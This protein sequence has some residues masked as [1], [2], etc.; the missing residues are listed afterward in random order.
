MPDD[1]VLQLTVKAN[2]GE[3]SDG[4]SQMAAVTQK[5][6]SEMGG[7]FEK[8]ESNVDR[9]QHSVYEARE[10]VTLLGE[11]VGVRLPRAVASLLARIGPLGAVLEVAFP[12]L[13]ALALVDVVS[14]LIEKHE[15][16]AQELR[17]SAEEETNLTI[18]DRDRTESL[19]LT[20]QKLE[21]QIGKIENRPSANKL[22]EALLEA[23]TRA[24]ELASSLESDFTKFGAQI[25]KDTG[26]VTNLEVALRNVPW[27]QVAIASSTLGVGIA[28]SAAVGVT[29]YKQQAESLRGVQSAM[30][31]VDEARLQMSETK[32][33]ADQAAAIQTLHNAYLNLKNAA[34][35]ALAEVKVDSPKNVELIGALT[36]S[37]IHATASMADMNEMAKNL[38][39]SLKSAGQT[40]ATDAAERAAKSQKEVLNQRLADIDLEKSRVHEL[41]ESGKTDLSTWLATQQQATQAATGAQELYHAA[42][43]KIYQD[44]GLA[45]KADAASKELGAE[46]TKDLAKETEELA[47]AEEKH[48][49]E[50]Q[51]IEA[52]WSSIIGKNVTEEW[53][54]QEKAVDE[55]AQA[56]YTLLRSQESLNQAKGGEGKY[57]PQIDAIKE[58]V[59]ARVL[60]KRQEAEQLMAIY[61]QEEAD[62]QASIQ[63]EIASKQ[64]LL[65][66]AKEDQAHA[67]SLYGANSPEAIA[68]QAQYDKELA[69]FNDLQAKKLNSQKQSDEKISAEQQQLTIAL[70]NIQ[71]KYFDEVNH[72]L[73]TLVADWIK[74]HQS[75]KQVVQNMLVDGLVSL[76]QYV[77]GWVEKKAEMW[78][79]DKILGETA[80]T[81]DTASTTA[82]NVLQVI[83]YAAVASAAAAAGAAVGGPLAAAAAAAETDAVVLAYLPQASAREGYDVPNLGSGSVVTAL[84]SREMVLPQHL[85]EGVR[86]MTASSG[87]GKSRPSAVHFHF[88]PTV[89]GAFDVNK[90]GS[91]MF[92]FMKSKF[93]R[94][95]Y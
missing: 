93:S 35:E 21:D 81:V 94:M 54:K 5:A 18:K 2:V 1:A 31:A 24:D 17:K 80:K 67:T 45:A 84:H 15:K 52:E 73:N 7:S 57:Q 38:G 50:M 33:E 74:G 10:A 3:A 92:D 37:V 26:F 82:A 87:D 55:L 61:R 40:E 89:N 58:E 91:E 79:L 83:S 22:S 23:K 32:T 39:L 16:Y 51:K 20:N 85:A 27:E 29:A 48:R 11:E 86:Q 66:S 53:K 43:L 62:A 13:G 30:A 36:G 75:M 64:K 78:V 60:S 70:Q 4:L 49:Q 8:L 44:A 65:D 71:K 19:E 34:T 12:V 9:A 95:G 14:K 47:K 59:A 41:Y 42:V 90:H 25:E 28:A 69:G 6:T 77:A 46:K 72:D 88:N 76:A 63:R 56:E 68:A